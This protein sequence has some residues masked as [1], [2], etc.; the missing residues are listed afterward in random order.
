MITAFASALAALAMMQQFHPDA[1]LTTPPAVEKPGLPVAP[2][3]PE[4][5][6]GLNSMAST[7]VAV[8]AAA[9]NADISI[10]RNSIASTGALVGFDPGSTAVSV[11][12]ATPST[13]RVAY[14]TVLG[15]K[16]RM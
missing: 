16:L 5:S 4:R 13:G 9:P 8:A 2:P 6:I 10:G 14:T 3:K 11:V 12:P 1:P 7:G 15:F